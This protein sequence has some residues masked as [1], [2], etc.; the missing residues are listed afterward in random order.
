MQEIILFNV[1]LWLIGY[2]LEI[3]LKSM[4]ILKEGIDDYKAI[5][6]KNKHHRLHQLASFIPEL[7]EKELEILKGLTHFVYWAGRYPDPGS[8]KEHEAEDI[9]NI[10]EK[11]QIS[12]KDLF[13]LSAKVMHHASDIANIM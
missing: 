10:S 2:S 7:S 6:Q 5:E 1:L 4:M 3:C 8:G 13:T 12:E 11:H 9:F